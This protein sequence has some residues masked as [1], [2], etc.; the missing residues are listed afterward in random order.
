MYWLDF[1]PRLTVSYIGLPPHDAGEQESVQ[2]KEI[3]GPS[4]KYFQKIT[5]DLPM[6][7][8]RV[9]LIKE[10]LTLFIH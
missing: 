1:N 7:P 5:I 2:L 10:V 3:E 8:M 9:I 4:K 6:I